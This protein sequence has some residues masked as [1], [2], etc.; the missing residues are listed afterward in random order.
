MKKKG[1]MAIGLLTVLLNAN[2][3]DVSTY[4]PGAMPEGVVYS[5][6]VADYIRSK[7]MSKIKPEQVGEFRS[8]LSSLYI[9]SE[10]NRQ[11]AL[12]FL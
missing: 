11:K 3:Q 9:L 12:L 10:T 8:L 5:R 4:T 7:K 1:L 6:R 2:A